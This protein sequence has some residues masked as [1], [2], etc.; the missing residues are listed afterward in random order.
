MIKVAADKLVFVSNQ[1]KGVFGNSDKSGKLASISAD[2]I[3]TEIDTNFIVTEG[4]DPVRNY[5]VS[6]IRRAG[7]TGD[8]ADEYVAFA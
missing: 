3:F 4:S 8:S 1:V 7:G 5:Y 6:K 2:G